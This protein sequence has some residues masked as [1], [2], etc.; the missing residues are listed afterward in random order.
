MQDKVLNN[1][2]IEVL[3]NTI[4][5]EVIG[6]DSVSAVSLKDVKTTKEKELPCSGLF[7]AIGFNPNTSLFTGQLQ[8]DD[9]G[10]LITKPGST[11]TSQ[12]G[13]FAC[14]DVQ[15]KHYRQAISAAGSGCMAAL[16][17]ERY[18]IEQGIA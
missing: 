16:D 9:L 8:L 13:V 3:W 10:Y 2:K 11:H 4:V 6:K 17:C 15:D 18:L 7:Y 14:G 5:T 1:P 12:P